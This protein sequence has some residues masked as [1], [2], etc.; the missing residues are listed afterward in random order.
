[1]AVAIGERSLFSASGQAED[2]RPLSIRAAARQLNLAPSTVSRAIQEKYCQ[3]NGV[4][5]PIACLFPRGY[6]GITRAAVLAKVAEMERQENKHLSDAEVAR[7]LSQQGF[8]I[9]RRSVNLYRKSGGAK[10]G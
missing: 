6:R 8:E 1:M 5:H 2:L 10:E 7:R 4:V 3:I 9:S